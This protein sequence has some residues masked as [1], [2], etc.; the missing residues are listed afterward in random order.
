MKISFDTFHNGFR[1]EKIP[2]ILHQM[3]EKLR[4]PENVKDASF[5]WNCYGF[6]S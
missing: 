1:L 6:S 2:S 3:N 5:W 4:E